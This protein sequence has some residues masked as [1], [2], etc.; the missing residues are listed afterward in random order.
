MTADMTTGEECSA[1]LQSREK[2][3]DRGFTIVVAA[4][5]PSTPIILS[6]CLRFEKMPRSLAVF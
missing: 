3:K 5:G 1:S 2:E 6:G 4:D